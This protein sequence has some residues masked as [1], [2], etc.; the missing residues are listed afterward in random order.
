MVDQPANHALVPIARRTRGTPQQALSD[1]DAAI[2]RLAR[3]RP[4]I[5]D[6][7]LSTINL[8]REA[9]M[10][11][12]QLYHYLKTV[13]AVAD[14]WHGSGHQPQNRARGGSPGLKQEFSNM[15]DALGAWQAVAAI[16]HAE[17][18]HLIEQVE[19]L[20][21]ENERLPR[22]RR[23]FARGQHV[24]LSCASPAERRHARQRDWRPCTATDPTPH[25]AA[26][27]TVDPPR[28]WISRGVGGHAPERQYVRV[29]HPSDGARRTPRAN[30]PKP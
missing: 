14:R 18:E 19:A 22:R 9:G 13:P 11:R 29:D 10:S 5:T 21:A 8:A 20:R 3:G 27:R 15:Q 24:P 17:A 26:L 12:K 2:D 25:L 1:I 16:A 30:R 23:R 4:N 28:R 6:G 7:K